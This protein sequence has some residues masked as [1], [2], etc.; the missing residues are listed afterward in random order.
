MD[1][2]KLAAVVGGV[3]VTKVHVFVMVL[4]AGHVVAVCAW[5]FLNLRPGTYISIESFQCFLIPPA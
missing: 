1:V 3:E 2:R 5:L 4:A